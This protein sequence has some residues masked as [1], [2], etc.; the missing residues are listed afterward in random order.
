MSSIVKIAKI[1]PSA[2]IVYQFLVFFYLGLSLIISMIAQKPIIPFRKIPFLALGHKSLLLYCHYI[3][4]G[5]IKTIARRWP[6]FLI[7][8]RRVEYATREA[9]ICDAINNSLCCST[10]QHPPQARCFIIEYFS[11]M[12][13]LLM[14]HNDGFTSETHLLNLDQKESKN[15]LDTGLPS[16]D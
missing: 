16:T 4:A 14:H 1:A 3:V 15:V 7:L 8:W 6:H 10:G 12:P 11:I 2:S 13:N 9:W 5:T